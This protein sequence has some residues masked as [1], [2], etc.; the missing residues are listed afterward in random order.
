[1]QKP[2]TWTEELSRIFYVWIIFLGSSTLIRGYENITIDMVQRKLGERGNTIYKIFTDVLSLVF[3]ILM[4]F[5]GIKM[6][7]NTSFAHMQANPWLKISYLY[8]SLV[9]G[10]F[11][12][13]VFLV[14]NTIRNVLKLT[15][16]SEEV[17]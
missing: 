17:A 3:T 1:M 9:L 14:E 4:F 8:L 11:F 13:G 6:M 2:F 16:K 15:K 10:S 5:G 7:K 12:A